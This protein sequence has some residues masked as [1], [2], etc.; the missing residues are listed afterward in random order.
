VS[1]NA[2]DLVPQKWSTLVAARGPVGN[3]AQSSP[4]LRRLK[5]PPPLSDSLP[6]HLGE[7]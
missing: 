1:L 4:K 2:D 7:V 5:E 6:L 3:L